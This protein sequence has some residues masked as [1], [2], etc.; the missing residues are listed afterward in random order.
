MF[1]P[2]TQTDQLSI[3]LK[4]ILDS[5]LNIRHQAEEKINQ[6]LSENFGEF[7]IEL[8][9][10]IATENEN[11]E[12]RQISATIIKN[13][14]NNTKYTEEWFKL[15]DNIKK[16]IK[17]NVLS[18]LNSS[19]INVRKAAALA[20]AGICKIEIPKKQWLNIFDILI[21][22]SQNNNINVQLSSL[23]ALEYI[24]EEIKQG[25]IPNDTVAKLLNT[26]YS[27]L[28]NANV[29]PQITLY[30]L[31]S[32][33]KFLPFIKDFI[34]DTDSKL[35]FYNL[36]EQFVKNENAEIRKVTL[37][38][39]L[40]IVKLYYD[41]L[42]NFIDKIFAFS[43]IIIEKDIE[44]NKLLCIEIWNN[45]GL[46]EDYRLHYIKS[47]KK[48][49]HNF[50]QNYYQPLGEIA[51][52]YI[53][54]DNYDN[55]EDSISK[56]CSQL[57]SV[58][59]RCCLSDFLSNMKNYIRA[60]V[61]NPTEVIRYS[62]LNVF[63]SIICTSHKSEFYPIVKDSLVM[64]SDILLNNYPIHF[65]KLCANI[66]KNIT[67]Y[68]SEELINDTIFFD[69]M[70]ALYLELFKVSTNEVLYI[71]IFS[72]N[73]LIKNINWSEND[74]TN[75]LSKHT[76][77]LCKPIMNFCSDIKF[78]NPNC[79]ITC[80]SFFV[81]GTIGERSALDVK[82]QMSNLFKVLVVMFHST[83]ETN[84]FPN[85]EVCNYYQEYIASCLTGFLSTGMAEQNSTAQL[86]QYVIKSF[87]IR[88]SLYDEGIT[89]IGCIS[90][91]TQKYFDSVMPLIS[92]YL[93]RGLN[94]HN[95]PSICKNSIFCLSDIIRALENENK[96]INDFLPLI[97]NILSDNNID[98]SL[99]PHCFNVI[100][101]IFLNCPDDAFKSFE[102][103]MKVIG[104]A[105]QATQ[106][107]FN[108]NSEP[109]TCNYFI[110]LREHILEAI[111]CIFSAIKDINK[112]KEFI[113]FVNS[114]MNYINVIGN[115]EFARSV[116]IMKDGLFLIGDFCNCY[117]KDMKILLDTLLIH[118]MYDIIEKDKNESKDPTT[119]EG[120]IWTKKF[121]NEVLLNY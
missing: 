119:R 102:N 43:Q 93:K 105:M 86:L 104:G 91:F 58:M 24:Y 72:L 38:I 94:S 73:I 47:N 30:T 3:I 8:S 14:V 118:D 117:K 88:N 26:Y 42:Q 55:E 13:M 5:N 100:S 115:D 44:I 99:K 90:L 92:P 20:L 103:I 66:I 95:S 77:N 106:I 41:S 1:Q 121:I 31:K 89:L 28:N 32:I 56:A 75:V 71:I 111:T 9:K 78:Y 27:L 107:K 6:L 116:N 39:F 52:K 48:L 62:A 49:S 50:L 29:N 108:E 34:N 19:D 114:I 11:T 12:V 7:L 40:D 76:E 80:I 16:T 53:I 36:I 23:T 64:V 57:I 18:T 84:K 61:N 54:T 15:Q 46:E 96:Y 85:Q 25:D 22:T 17:D 37:Q 69:K 110:S 59:S 45:I 81:L 33:N 120:I 74:Q 82:N 67:K 87:E 10:K 21:N 35:K 98:Q 113:P 68:Y 60:N 65:K 4:S 112:T 109:E 101:D 83:L 2:N 63:N 97:L 51:L 70:I 79:N